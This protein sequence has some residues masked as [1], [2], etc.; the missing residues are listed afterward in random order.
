[1]ANEVDRFQDSN[2]IDVNIDSYIYSGLWLREFNK[3]LPVPRTKFWYREPG[4]YLPLSC[5]I[6]FVNNVTVVGTGASS[7]VDMSAC[8]GAGGLFL[9][10]IGGFSAVSAPSADTGS[11]SWT[12]LTARV[13]SAG[14]NMQFFYVLAPSASAT[15]T[16]TNGSSSFAVMDVLGFSGVTAFDQETGQDSQS[17]VETPGAIS[18]TDLTFIT[19]I[20]G[21]SSDNGGT[22]PTLSGPFTLLSFTPLLASFNYSCGTGYYISAGSNTRNP[23]WTT[24]GT[25]GVTQAT[26]SPSGAAVTIKQLAALGVG[27]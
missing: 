14:G 12:G 10:N 3:K 2:G 1:M 22:P 18:G 5:A 26:F 8:N 19:G 15:H 21:G 25:D 27:Q 17:S 24:N 4:L 9:A 23:G 11:N 6:A 13:G 16:F 20:G 7:A